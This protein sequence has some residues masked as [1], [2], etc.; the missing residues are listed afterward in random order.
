MEVWAI[1]WDFVSIIDSLRTIIGP[2]LYNNNQYE[3][4]CG[5]LSLLDIWDSYFIIKFTSTFQGPIQDFCRRGCQPL[6]GVADMQFFSKFSKNCVKLITF[7]TVGGGGGGT[8]SAS[9]NA[10]ITCIYINQ[11]LYLL[12]VYYCSRLRYRCR[13]F[14]S[15]N[16]V[17]WLRNTYSPTMQEVI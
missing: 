15:Q 9:A 13:K 5:I 1:F 4:A 7:W 8:G 17:T 11:K 14:W 10:F 2:L 16:I 3:P 6:G 12:T